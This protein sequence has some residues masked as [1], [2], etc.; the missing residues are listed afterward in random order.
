M[1]VI[2][3]GDF[4]VEAPSIVSKAERVEFSTIR[5]GMRCA[6]K[7]DTVIC[8]P[9]QR[10]AMKNKLCV[11]ISG[12]IVILAVIVSC[13]LLYRD[14]WFGQSLKMIKAEKGIGLDMRGP[15]KPDWE[16]KLLYGNKFY[17]AYSGLGLGIFDC[18]AILIFLAMKAN[19]PRV[20]F[21]GVMLSAKF[22]LINAMKMFY[23]EPRPY[24]IEKGLIGGEMSCAADFGNPSG[25]ALLAMA[26]AV[27]VELDLIK[28]C[29][30]KLPERVGSTEND[31][32][33][34]TGFKMFLGLMA[35]VIPF[36]IAYL[37]GFARFEVRTN[38]W[39]QI[40]YGML[41]GFWAGVVGFYCVLE[42]LKTHTRKINKAENTRSLCS[43]FT[44]ATILMFVALAIQL[45]TYF[46]MDRY[47][48][49]DELWVENIRAYCPDYEESAF[50]LNGSIKRSALS[51]TGYGLYIGLLL[52][53]HFFK[54]R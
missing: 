19:R 29:L 13:E 44:F 15:C 18:A 43:Y 49:I 9:L 22:T 32:C 8:D 10:C 21:Y 41:L 25:F 47:T 4:E 51:F 11:A 28:N 40:L 46:V 30:V 5:A 16:N 2:A 53:N 39:N 14:L 50:F 35:T 3:Q 20:V 54:G 33:M 38:T 12:P 27:G 17:H 31:T 7:V 36:A 1:K 37:V 45:T 42:P 52:N 26:F 6:E 48:K 23:G 34:W 24:W